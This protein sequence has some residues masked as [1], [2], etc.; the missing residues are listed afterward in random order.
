MYGRAYVMAVRVSVEVVDPVR[1]DRN[2]VSRR[3]KSN[4]HHPGPSRLLFGCNGVSR[5]HYASSAPCHGQI[6]HPPLES[7]EVR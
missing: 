2:A 6:G 5:C 7:P 1:Q 4:H 3:R